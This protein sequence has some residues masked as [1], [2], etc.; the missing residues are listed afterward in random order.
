MSTVELH[1]G[2]EAT[3]PREWRTQLRMER[4]R[5]STKTSHARHNHEAYDKTSPLY[6]GSPMRYEGMS[7]K[8]P[9]NHLWRCTVMNDM[10]RLSIVA[11]AIA[12]RH[13][14]QAVEAMTPHCPYAT[15]LPCYAYRPEGCETC[16]ALGEGAA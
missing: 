12:L 2:A 10:E 5:L 15:I 6:R 11:T 8:A 13:G 3:I 14:T 1:D 7:Q 16:R 9:G 4:V